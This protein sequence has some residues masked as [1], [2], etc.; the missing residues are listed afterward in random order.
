[1]FQFNMIFALCLFAHH[2]HGHD[3]HSGLTYQITPPLINKETKQYIL[4]NIVDAEANVS[5]PARFSLSVN[6]EPHVPDS[7]DEN[8]IRFKSIHT[9]KN[10]I[11]TATYSRGIGPVF[12]PLPDNVHNGIV[13]VSKGYEYL[14]EEV[15]FNI[16]KSPLVTIQML[17]RQ[18]PTA[19]GS[20]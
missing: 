14:P 19:Q 2:L 20:S 13:F 10:E 6:N 1:M 12:I 7:L 15:D 8:G 4:L 3:G 17:L 5:I 11:F 16:E 18:W 9:G